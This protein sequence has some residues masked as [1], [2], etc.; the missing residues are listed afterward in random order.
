MRRGS[1]RTKKMGTAH[2]RTSVSPGDLGVLAGAGVVGG[3]RTCKVARVWSSLVQANARGEHYRRQR[4]YMILSF[5]T[6]ARCAR[7]V[8]RAR[9]LPL[10][11]AR[12][13]ACGSPRALSYYTGRT[14]THSA[15][16]DAQA[17]LAQP[18]L[19]PEPTAHTARASATHRG[20]ADADIECAKDAEAGRKTHN[21]LIDD[22]LF[23]SVASLLAT[24][25]V[26]ADTDTDTGGDETDLVVPRRCGRRARR[27]G[28]ERG[29][30]SV[31]R[32][33][34]RLGA[35]GGGWGWVARKRRASGAGAGGLLVG[36]SRSARMRA[37]EVRLR[38]GWK[39]E[40]GQAGFCCL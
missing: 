34:E 39:R 32:G 16:Q 2:A 38:V 30:V 33:R 6:D 12:T 14:S 7:R 28:Y 3:E 26:R 15:A 17:A 35:Y 40:R 27:G 23:P 18:R 4:T 36:R 20:E 37:Q 13:D 21:P 11:H 22:I 19:R 25:L 1:M 9:P 31:Q 10:V 5:P 8:L 24:G 29:G